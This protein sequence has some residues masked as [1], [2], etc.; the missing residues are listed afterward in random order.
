MELIKE[1]KCIEF[2]DKRRYKFTF[3]DR[4]VRWITSVTTKLEEYREEGLER[5]RESVGPEE[6]N[7]NMEEAGEWGRLVHHACFLLATGGAVLYE[8]PSYQTIGIQNEEVAELVKQNNFIRQQLALKSIP[9][10]TIDDQFRFLQCKKFKGWLDAVKPEVLYAESVV[11]SLTY[12]IA[13][14]IDFLFRVK[15]GNYP[16]AGEKD[17]FLPGGIILPDVKTGAWSKRHFLQMGAYRK[18]VEESLGESVVATVG[19][20]LKAKTKTGLNTLVHLA[21][22]ADRDFELYQHVAAIYD[23]KHKN[24][25]PQDFEFESVLMGTAAQ[26]VLL[27]I[28]IPNPTAEAQVEMEISVEPKEGRAAQFDSDLAKTTDIEA[29]PKEKQGT[30]DKSFLRTSRRKR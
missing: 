8:P 6:A 5:Y 23:D 11:Y 24:D 1:I 30:V 13:G 29:E 26:S 20:H 10:L 27:G 21:D 12:D 28:T 2:F 19:I 14:R 3:I 4:A 18:A 22:E 9:H 17:V 15:E 16:I 7:R 25:T